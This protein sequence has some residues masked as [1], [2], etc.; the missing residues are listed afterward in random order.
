MICHAMAYLRRQRELLLP[1]VVQFADRTTA[2]RRAMRNC[3]SD[4]SAAET[5]ILVGR[6]GKPMGVPEKPK[7]PGPDD[8]A[9]HINSSRRAMSIRFERLN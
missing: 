8:M 6:Q 2:S 3:E 5:T 7:R 4:P 1:E 9:E